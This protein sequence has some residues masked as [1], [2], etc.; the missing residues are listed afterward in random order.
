MRLDTN[1]TTGVKR[2]T[3][4]IHVLYKTSFMAIELTLKESSDLSTFR[5]I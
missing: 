3:K 1:P 5:V 2:K 4:S